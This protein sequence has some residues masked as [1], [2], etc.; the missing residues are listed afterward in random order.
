MQIKR[1]LDDLSDISRINRRK[2]SLQ[3]EALSLNATLDE[4]VAQVQSRIAASGQ[5]LELEISE[6][7]MPLWADATRLRQIF[8]NLLVNA[9]RYSPPETAISLSARTSDGLAEVCIRDQGV[10]MSAETQARIFEP[11]FQAP[12]RAGETQTSRCGLGVGLTL[13]RSLVEMHAGSIHVE[14]EGPGQGSQFQV[15]L[16]LQAAPQTEAVHEQQHQDQQPQQVPKASSPS[17]SC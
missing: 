3:C 7:P 17:A 4:V 13:A 12:Q 16:P 8:A 5:R 10:G 14:S 2:L 6:D 11:F 15:V 9:S 1:L